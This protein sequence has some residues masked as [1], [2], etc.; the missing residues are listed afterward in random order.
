MPLVG[1]PLTRGGASRGLRRG[2]QVRAPRGGQR[3]AQDEVTRSFPGCGDDRVLFGR[4][5]LT[6]TQLR[7][8]RSSTAPMDAEFTVPDKPC[9]QPA[10]D[11]PGL[12]Y[13]H[14]GIRL[15]PVGTHN[16]DVT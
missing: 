15:R 1:N 16:R 5:T 10:R 14:L 3:A 8:L 12:L 9:A 11:S 2:G 13:S 6:L 4:R 7:E